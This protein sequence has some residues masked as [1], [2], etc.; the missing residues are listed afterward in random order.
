MGQDIQ[1]TLGTC[2]AQTGMTNFIVN[3]MHL[4][5]AEEL[6]T[7]K[8]VETEKSTKPTQRLG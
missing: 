8:N 7:S 1:R 4:M 2:T 3:V 6:A 5:N